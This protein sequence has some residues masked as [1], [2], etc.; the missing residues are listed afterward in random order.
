MLIYNAEAELAGGFVGG[1]RAVGSRFGV[2]DGRCGDEWSGDG[3]VS[4]P[5]SWGS[6]RGCSAPL[7][8]AIFSSF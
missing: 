2:A 5:W 6:L 3:A 7:F 4:T 1:G 8:L